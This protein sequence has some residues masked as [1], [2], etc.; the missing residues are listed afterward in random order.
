LGKK[1]H[2]FGYPLFFHLLILFPS[3]SILF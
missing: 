1:L 2:G 3:R